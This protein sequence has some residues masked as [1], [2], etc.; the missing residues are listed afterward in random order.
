MFV[1]TSVLSETHVKSTI[2][3]SRAVMH[4]DD[5]GTHKCIGLQ[6][7]ALSDMHLRKGD[8]AIDKY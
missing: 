8:H 1:V 4:M 3:T 5:I 7:V 6:R 2:F